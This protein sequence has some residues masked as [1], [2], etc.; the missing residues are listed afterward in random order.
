VNPPSTSP[1]AQEAAKVSEKLAQEQ[2]TQIKRLEGEIITNKVKADKVT[3]LFARK[4][5]N[6][7]P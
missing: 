3:L 7:T 2:S 6:P 1:Q 5:L 4:T